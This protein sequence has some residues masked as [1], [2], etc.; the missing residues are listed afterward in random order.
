MALSRAQAIAPPSLAVLARR[1]QGTTFDVRWRLTMPRGHSTLLRHAR[2]HVDLDLRR[3]RRAQRRVD[4]AKNRE[5]HV[6]AR[7]QE[8]YLIYGED[9]CWKMPPFRLELFA[10]ELDPYL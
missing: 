2:R 1:G 4:D 5:P 10:H 3:S 6:L 7:L 8:H 9:S